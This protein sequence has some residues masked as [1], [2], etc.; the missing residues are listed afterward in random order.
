VADPVIYTQETR[1]EVLDQG[2]TVEVTDEGVSV[3][4]TE[5]SVEVATAGFAGPQGL[6]GPNWITPDTTT[7]IDG[8]LA[9]ESG[10]VRKAVGGT[11]YLGPGDVG[12]AAFSDTGDFATASQGG[13]ADSAVQPE[14]LGTAAYANTGDFATASQG[15]LAD[16]AV[17]PEDL[18]T[19]AYANT[20]DFATA[21]QGGLA[22]SAVQPGDALTDLSSGA[23]TQG[24]T[25]RADGA[26]G[27]EWVDPYP[28]DA[29]VY[30][31]PPIPETTISFD[32]GSN[33]FTLSP[34]GATWRYYRN[35]VQHRITGPVSVVLP[36]TPPAAGPWFFYIDSDDG[37]L[38]CSQTPWTLLATDTRVFVA[39]IEY[40]SA[41]TPT[42]LLYDER[43]PADIPRNIH[44]YLHSTR[45]SQYG[46]G[47]ALSG[48]T[49]HGSTNAHNTFGVEAAVIW[50]ETL[51]ITLEALADPDGA[52]PTYAV[53]YPSSGEW[54]WSLESV[55]YRYTPGGFMYYN[56]AGVEV[57]GTNGDYINT[58]LLLTPSGPQI[59]QG[60]AA[61]NSVEEAQAERF[62]DLNLAGMPIAEFVARHQLTWRLN[63]SYSTSGK[64]RL[65]AVA[66]IEVSVAGMAGGGDAG[67]L[68][69][70][71][72]AAADPHAVAG[73]VQEGDPATTLSVSATD[74][75]LGRQSA[76]GGAVEEIACTVAGRDLLDDATASDQ[77][78]TLG[79][80]S[81]I[82]DRASP[83]E[84]GATTPGAGHFSSL[85]SSDLS[86]GYLPK[87]SSG[88][89][90]ADS[91]VYIDGSNRV[92]IGTTS[93]TAGYAL[94]VQGNMKVGYLESSGNISIGT[95]ALIGTT[96][97]C[98]STLSEYI[99]YATAGQ[100]QIATNYAVRAVFDASG[101]V[102]FGAAT[103]VGVEIGTAIS[104]S[105]AQSRDGVRLGVNV[106]P[107]ILFEYDDTVQG[108]DNYEGYLRFF[109]EGNLHA[110]ISTTGQM[111]LG[112]LTPD[113]RLTIGSMGV[114]AASDLVHCADTTDNQHLVIR[115]DGTDAFQFRTAI[116]GGGYAP[117]TVKGNAVG[118]NTTAPGHA[119]HVTGN[120]AASGT[121]TCV[122]YLFLNSTNAGSEGA[123]IRMQGGADNPEIFYIDRAGDA[124]RIFNTAVT[125]TDSWVQ[126]FNNDATYKMHICTDG[127]V[128]AGSN[129]VTAP[130]AEMECHGRFYRQWLT[131]AGA[132]TMQRFE[133]VLANATGGSWTLTLPAGPA[134]GDTV[135][136]KAAVGAGY[137]LTIGRNSSNIRGASAD[138]TVSGAAYQDLELVYLNATTGW[139]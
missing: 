41:S 48:Y 27:I 79:F 117:I 30:G 72:E 57:A 77:R 54:P 129:S 55:P 118:I 81:P 120:I 38:L 31:F 3:T 115:Y 66:E 56:A 59:V 35:G 68:L 36:G 61:H 43:H 58:F 138:L 76:G 15:G 73:Y 109:G 124:L 53:R 11:D 137:T 25:L 33:T 107:R 122:N 127:A 88:G 92:G 128:R 111:A 1:V 103:P 13:L 90:L 50:D 32:S 139:V 114:G 113:T 18:G 63:A 83:G 67:A 5:S 130:I 93:P 75:I 42:Y 21:S 100:I 102:G 60:Q 136:I 47:G 86:T 126:I 78:T 16:S 10:L 44:A 39:L 98:P 119:L 110:R 17:Q 26:T 23:A 125:D 82:L 74:R 9:G 62:Q 133:Q 134:A 91:P 85:Y 84:I 7:S 94:H 4:I 116:G 112:P 22:D 71:H 37:A 95:W 106:S 14:D 19:A 6:P 8:L 97:A 101:N 64:A 49:L 28:A 123:E 12:S 24:Q 69:L 52:T 105:T 99:T 89:S 40:D 51:R 104:D 132:Y 135:K 108:V 121:L 2:T 34:V 65:E 96:F 29:E 70:A 46:S 20:G 87:V 80:T 131:K 45:G